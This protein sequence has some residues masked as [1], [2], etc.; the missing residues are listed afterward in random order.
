MTGP[1]IIHPG[2]NGPLVYESTVPLEVPAYFK[3]PRFCRWALIQSADQMTTVKPGY[4]KMDEIVD[5]ITERTRALAERKETSQTDAL[6]AAGKGA[7]AAIFSLHQQGLGDA[8]LVDRLN[9]LG[10]IARRASY[11]AHYL[12]QTLVETPRP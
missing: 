1:E 6:A 4:R 9:V 2:S 7:E 11:Q 12:A 5:S 10:I 3:N 8:F